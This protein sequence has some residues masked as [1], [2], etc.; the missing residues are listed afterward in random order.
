MSALTRGLQRLN[1]AVDWLLCRIV[2]S[3]AVFMVVVLAAQVLGRYVFN[4]SSVSAVEAGQYSFVWMSMLVIC[5]AF[6]RLHADQRQ[7]PACDQRKYRG[8]VVVAGR[9][10]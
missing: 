7:R 8:A 2:V 4:L 5:V 10:P 9:P 3:L 6:P 1:A